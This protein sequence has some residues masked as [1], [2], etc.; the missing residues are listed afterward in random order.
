MSKQ[1]DFLDW[2]GQTKT[3][4]KLRYAEQNSDNDELK[5]AYK[6]SVMDYERA[7]MYHTGIKLWHN[8]RTAFREHKKYYGNQL[9]KPS[10]MLIVD[11]NTRM[12]E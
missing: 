5:S 6:K 10:S 2:L 1:N 11:F 7:I 3:L 12:R 9:R 4:K 8:H